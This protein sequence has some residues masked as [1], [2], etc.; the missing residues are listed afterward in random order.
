M[1][2]NEKHFNPKSGLR[3]AL[4]I[5]G[6][7]IQLILMSV[8]TAA[9]TPTPSPITKSDPPSVQT[10][11]T[12]GRITKWAGA[13]KNGIGTIGDSV[14]TES[15]G[16]I[17]IDVTNPSAKLTVGGTVT[18]TGIINT[19]TQYNIGGNRVVSTAG[20]ENI[21][22]GI[23][24]G[25]SN[26]SGD[27]NVFVGQWAGGGNTT[28]RGNVFVGA[29]AGR[30]NTTGNYNAFFGLGSGQNSTTGLGNANL[31]SN[32]ISKLRP[33]D[34]SLVATSNVGSVPWGLAFDGISMW[35]TNVGSNSVS[36]R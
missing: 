22:V 32:T 2:H 31:N 26:T 21:F 17:G 28:G 11:S 34:G 1:V 24:A 30:S 19:G 3:I 15:S 35:V 36:K 10:P 9:Q 29:F 27:Q 14:I 6:S 18:A 8:A 16:N 12:V 5:T 25:Q 7:I 13:S 4:G 20:S 33:S 23:S